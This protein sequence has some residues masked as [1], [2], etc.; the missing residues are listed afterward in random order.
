[1]REGARDSMPIMLAGW[2][3]EELLHAA[4][5]APRG[6]YV[7]LP[8]TRVITR[9]GWFQLITPSL[10]QG[11]LNEVGLSVLAPDV[12]DAVIDATIAEYA[13]LGLFFRWRVSPDSAP[14]DLAERL[15]ARGLDRG[16]SV[17]MAGL[18]ERA[19][20]PRAGITVDRVGAE[21]VDDF[22]RVMAE[23]WEMDPAP[24]AVLNQKLIAGPERGHF[25]FLARH[26]GEPAGTATYASLGRSAHLM[27]AVV[28]SQYRGL[29]LYRALTEARLSHAAARGLSLA[30]SQARDETSAPILAHLG[31]VTVCRFPVFTSAR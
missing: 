24:L 19:S 28:L 30:T 15:A 9:P 27:G 22:N 26:R 5:I 14:E 17:A 8:D 1:M 2:S 13:R 18:T 23:G 16:E 29:G 21:T 20:T 7:A 12:A 31:F 3:T 10:R 4:V 6:A 25:L 11:G